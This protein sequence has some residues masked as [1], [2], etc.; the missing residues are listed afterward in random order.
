MRGDRTQSLATG[1]QAAH[2]V[3]VGVE[4]ADVRNTGVRNAL[5]SACFPQLF[6]RKCGPLSVML[7]REDRRDTAVIDS[8]HKTNL[9]TPWPLIGSVLLDSGQASPARCRSE[10]E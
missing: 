10:E 1:E 3:A 7:F 4:H 9:V 6:G 8:H 2:N 5:L